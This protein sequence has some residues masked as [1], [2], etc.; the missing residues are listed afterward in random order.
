MLVDWRIESKSVPFYD[1]IMTEE[2]LLFI[3]KQPY[4]RMLI[5]KIF[6]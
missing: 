6:Y 4:L 5:P 2:L 1:F 3:Q